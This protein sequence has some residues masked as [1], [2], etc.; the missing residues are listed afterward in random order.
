MIPKL[1]LQA[2]FLTLCKDPFASFV[3][4]STGEVSPLRFSRYN[5][6]NGLH[7]FSGS[8]NPI[9]E[10]HRHIFDQIACGEGNKIYELSIER[11]GKESLTF[12]VMSERL[13]QFAGYAPVLITRA[14]RFIEKAGILSGCNPIFHIG[15]DTILRM[16]D[17]YGTIGIQGLAAK[18]VVYD[19]MVDG[20][21]VGLKNLGYS[22]DNCVQAPTISESLLGVSSTKIRKNRDSQQVTFGGGIIEG[23]TK[24]V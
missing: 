10:G 13:A 9:H 6:T 24:R 23:P 3:V 1:N 19:R 14:P 16:K 12:E 18:F 5:G 17:D 21:I 7:I 15:G 4:E 20:A 22:L 11:I 2:A 8:F